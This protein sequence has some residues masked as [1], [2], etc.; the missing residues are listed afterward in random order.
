MSR[1]LSFSRTDS[2]PYQAILFTNAV[3][4]LSG[5]FNLILY[6]L[7]RPKIVVGPVVPKGVLPIHIRREST[8]VSSQKIGCLSPYDHGIVF[9]NVEGYSRHDSSLEP[10]SPSRTI[11]RPRSSYELQ[12]IPSPL[13]PTRTTHYHRGASLQIEEVVDICPR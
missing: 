2:L 8:G 5:V 4:A 12:G 10:K 6:F 11:N 1:W 9:T 3:F 7:T 13:S